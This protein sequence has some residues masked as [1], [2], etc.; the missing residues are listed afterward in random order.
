MKTTFTL[1]DAAKF[2]AMHPHTLEAMAR[3]GRV[4]G[5]KPAKRWVFLESD[6]L[7]FL[8]SC[9]YQKEETSGGANGGSTVRGIVNQRTRQTRQKRKSST[10]KD[11][12][13]YGAKATLE[14]VLLLLGTKQHS[15]G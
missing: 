4:I 8:R 5:Y 11:V 13:N 1:D 7:E 3:D 14:N 15:T 2:L 10:I 6:L 12:Q 9:R